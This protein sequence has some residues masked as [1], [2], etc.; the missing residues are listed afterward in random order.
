MDYGT[1]NLAS[2]LRA[3]TSMQDT[4]A[5][6]IAN[7]ASTG[8]KR[9][10]G[11]LIPF[12]T[13][14]SQA[15]GMGGSVSAFQEFADLDQG[16]LITTGNKM[17]VALQ[18]DGFLKLALKD[19]PD[20]VFYSRGGA[21]ARSA[22]GELVTKEGYLVLDESGRSIELGSEG[23]I[24]IRS[25][26]EILSGTTG[27]RLASFGVFRF[28][29]S[30]SLQSLGAGLYR[31]SPASGEALPDRFT[32]VVQGSLERS[33]VNSVTEMVSMISTQRHFGAITRALNT[34]N[35]IT[36]QLFQMAQG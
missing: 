6:N 23:D 29:Q 4:I 28:D 9:R 3:L 14:L 10:Q 24:L 22:D 2:T 32:Q 30:S 8:F 12:E 27:D 35:Q 18:G 5:N 34:V 33:N 20:N 31:E 25:S 19:N 11:A 1:I 17:N 16:D 21:L 7:V 26:G 36:S 15:Q 13:E